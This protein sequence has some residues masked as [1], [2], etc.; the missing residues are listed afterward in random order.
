[1]SK[2]P[3]PERAHPTNI[4]E[5]HPCADLSPAA[6]RYL[7]AIHDLA[8][9]DEPVTQAAVARHVGVSNPTALEMV[10]RLR[11]LG[12]LEPNSLKP[13]RAGTS[14]ALVLQSRRSATRT[15]A[16]DVLGLGEV[17]ADAEAE[18]LAPEVSALLGR[19]LTAWKAE[20]RD[21]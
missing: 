17:D 8:E 11:S 12:M 4:D 16:R 21:E 6:S 2:P 9:D 19:H 10:K 15:L 3:G 14:A 1:M 13:T 7:L 18:R 20:H 5:H